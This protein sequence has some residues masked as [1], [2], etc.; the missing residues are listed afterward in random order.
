MTRRLFLALA[1][2]LVLV[3]S[4]AAMPLR[5]V[6]RVVP[7]YVSQTVHSLFRRAHD[8]RVAW[9]QCQ[10]FRSGMACPFSSIFDAAPARYQP[11][12]GELDAWVVVVRRRH[13]DRCWVIGLTR[14]RRCYQSS[15]SW[16]TEVPAMPLRALSRIPAS[17]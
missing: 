17:K 10:P 12:W 15:F 2:G 16:L 8:T 13:V 3:S 1:L 5:Q 6:E 7:S 9:E 4:A 14:A 11:L